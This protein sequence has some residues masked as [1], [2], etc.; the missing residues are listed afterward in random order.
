[1]GLTQRST[2]SRPGD[3]C[4]V[5]TEAG[6]T[7]TTPTGEG[8]REEYLILATEIILTD[9]T[10]ILIIKIG[11]S[12]I[13]KIDSLKKKKKPY[14]RHIL[15]IFFLFPTCYKLNYPKT[16]SI[17]RNNLSRLFTTSCENIWFKLPSKNNDLL[18]KNKAVVVLVP[19]VTSPPMSFR[20]HPCAT[21]NCT[22]IWQL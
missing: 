3:P 18:N 15:E 12:L 10:I 4:P 14:F 9:F 19:F 7:L 11:I 17:P 22:I 21:L 5:R 13:Y 8:P 6:P 16:Q 2:P 20:A 1:M